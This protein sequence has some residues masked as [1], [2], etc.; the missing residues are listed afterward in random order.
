M[1]IS[2]SG[3]AVQNWAASS[4]VEVKEKKESDPIMLELKGAVK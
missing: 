4:L 1:S 3:V 2:E